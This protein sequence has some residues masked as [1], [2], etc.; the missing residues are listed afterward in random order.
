[1]SSTEDIIGRADVNDLDAILAVTN[2]DVDEVDPRREGQRRRHLHV[3]LRRRAPARRSSKLYEKAKTSQWNGETDL[4]WDIEVDQ[5]AVVVANA[6][7]ERRDGFGAT[8]TVT[9]TP[10]EKWGEKEWLEL[11]I[12]SP[13]LDAQPVHA[14]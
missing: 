12:E 4:A 3:G 10:F 9:G 2:T 6:A 5:E 14:R 13:E 7:P 8:S 11:G 1:M